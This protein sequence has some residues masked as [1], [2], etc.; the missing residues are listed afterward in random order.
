MEVDRPGEREW[1]AV[2]VK[3]QHERTVP[4]ALGRLGFERYVPLCRAVRRWA[5]GFKELDVP[6]FA[7]FVFAACGATKPLPSRLCPLFTT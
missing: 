5:E 4:Y 6:V 1:F 3:P 2:Q 7:G